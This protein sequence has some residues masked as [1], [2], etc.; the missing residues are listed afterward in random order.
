MLMH[1]WTS[2]LR[3]RDFKDAEQST[4]KLAR[5]RWKG[6]IAW[7]VGMAAMLLAFAG[8][9]IMGVKL[10]DKKLLSQ[11]MAAEVPLVMNPKS[12]LKNFVKTSW[13]VSIPSAP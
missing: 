7:S 1:L 10:E 13:G 2:D 4:R 12:F 8:I 6:M 5:A 11:K 3:Q 9:K